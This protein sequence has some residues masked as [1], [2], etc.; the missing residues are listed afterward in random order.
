[1]IRYLLDRDQLDAGTVMTLLNAIGLVNMFQLEIFFFVGA[2][3]WE[4]HIFIA[5][6]YY[7]W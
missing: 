2:R 7:T 3:P 4:M 6:L 5:V 1:M